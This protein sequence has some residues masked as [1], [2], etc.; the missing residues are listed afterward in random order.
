[1]K[2]LKL[3]L[4]SSAALLL[5]LSACGGTTAASSSPVAP[6]SSTTPVSSTIAVDYAAMA[7]TALAQVG[8][9]LSKYASSGATDNFDLITS[10]VVTGADGKDYSYTIVY[11]VATDYASYMAISSDGKVCQ[12][13]APNTVEGGTDQKCKLHAVAKFADTEYANSDF[14][15]LVKA[16]SLYTIPLIYSKKVA[17]GTAVV[18]SGIVTGVYGAPATGSTSYYSIFVGDGDYGMTIYSAALPSTVNLANDSETNGLDD[19]YVKVSGT[20][21]IYSN[22]YEVKNATLTAIEKTAA[23]K[24]TAPT[25]LALA[26]GNVPT[27]AQDM[28]SR[29]ATITDGL[30]TS[31]A[32][33]DGANLTINVKIGT[34]VYTIFENSSYCAAA[35][36]A[37]FKQT[38]SGKTEATL[39]GVNDVI[40]I[41]GFTSF[42]TTPQIVGAKVTKW[43]EGVA[44]SDTPITIADLV[45]KGWTADTSYSLQGFVTGYYSGIG[46]PKSGMFIADADAGLDIYGFTGDC[47]TFTVGTCV[48]VVGVPSVH[49]GLIEFTANKITV[50]ATA[51]ITAKAATVAEVGG[52]TG[53]TSSAQARP[54]HATGILQAAVTG[55]YGTDNVTAKVTI[56]NNETLSVYLHKSNITKAQYEAWTALAE[57]DE[58]E[59]TGWIANYEKNVAAWST[60]LAKGVQVVSPT[61][62]KTTAAASI[63]KIT[64]TMTVAGAVAAAKGAAVDTIGFYEGAY[65]TN[66]YQGVFFGDGAA[67]IV[68][69]K[70]A[71]FPIGMAKGT[72]LHVI[73][74]AAP[75]SGLAEIDLSAA[76][77][78]ITVLPKALVADTV[79]APVVNTTVSAALA[80]A[81]LNHEFDITGA[82]LKTITKAV[83]AGTTD[84]TYVVTIGTL[85][86][87]LFVKKTS[88]EADVYTKLAAAK[89]GDTLA[90]TAFGGQYVSNKVATYQLVAPQGLTVTAA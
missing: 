43:T 59:F 72:P 63:A 84:G 60:G 67:S 58:V 40:S 90:F 2:K 38:R 36:Y 41:A 26:T 57:G 49:N 83:V 76:T 80:A 54:I 55:T 17:D 14:N 25:T 7:K 4:V 15:V 56:G 86:V 42:Y 10:S 82:V 79:V 22:L 19:N 21:S 33:T 27:I 23:P 45:N 85:D 9:A 32:G 13:S 48:T 64:P 1:M 62:V 53:L 50:T 78:S 35:D 28:A 51:D 71:S 77:S 68:T 29:P 20:I 46:T 44:P 31:V 39:I 70:G 24:V 30:V 37:T 11:S 89:V 66:M 87:T 47:S 88:L 74:V 18:F 16:V 3:I 65:L 6:V 34:S 61:I 5:G 81:D 12:V 8:T 75:Y 52:V 69:Y 73:G